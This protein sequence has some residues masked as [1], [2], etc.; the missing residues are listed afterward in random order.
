MEKP[1][2]GFVGQ[3]YIGKNYAD[4]IESRG[5]QTVRYALEEAYKNNKDK[6]KDCDIVFVAVPTPTTQS[7]F[8]DSIVRGAVALAGAGKIVVIKSTILPGTTDSIQE[9]NSDKVVLYSPE[10]LVAAQAVHDASHPVRNIIGLPKNDAAHQDAAKRVLEVLPKAQFE[11]IMTA[12]EAELTKYT[13]NS[14]L[15]TKVIFANVF[16]DIAKSLGADWSVVSEAV[17]ADPRIGPS[18]L[19]VV[20]ASLPGST[21]GRGAG[22]PCLPKDLAAL[23]WLYEKSGNAQD[24]NMA[25]FKAL[26]EK[27]IELL[28]QSGKDVDILKGIYGENLPK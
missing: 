2:I 18:H 1:L 10:F 19:K 9:E 5:Y 4:D 17:G 27:N 24:L 23:R 12:R 3:G 16:F 25:F 28:T 26:E 14:F 15:Y 22:G 6:I 13:G 21:A 7:G 20:D 11:K 8:D